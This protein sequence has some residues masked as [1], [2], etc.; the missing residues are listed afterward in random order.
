MHQDSRLKNIFGAV[1]RAIK[2]RYC[3]QEGRLAAGF[4]TAYFSRLGLQSVNSIKSLQV[5]KFERHSTH[6]AP[7]LICFKS[8]HSTPN[9]DASCK[10]GLKYTS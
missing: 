1:G 2:L 3:H 7:R 9:A 5:Q 10:L 4:D 8:N 6:T